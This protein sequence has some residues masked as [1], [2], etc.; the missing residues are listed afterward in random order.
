MRT[1]LLAAVA[2]LALV[3]AN[4]ASAQGLRPGEPASLAEE[5]DVNVVFVGYDEDTIDTDEFLDELPATYE[6]VVRSRLWYGVTEKLGIT[7]TFHYDVSFTDGEWED[8]FFGY[9][10]SIARP[11][12]DVDGLERTLFQDQY[13]AQPGRALDV[14]TNHFI[15]AAA[16]EKYL[17]ANSPGVDTSEYTIFY[18]NWY[19]RSDFEFHTYVKL[20]EP[21]PD[22]GYNFGLNRQTRKIIA[23][24]GTT[25][26]DEE[27]GLGVLGVNRVW[28]HDL[29]AGPES[30]TDNW[31][32]TDADLDGDGQEDYRLPPVWEYGN[33]AAG[34]PRAADALSSDLGKLTRFVA[35]NLLFTTSPLYPPYQNADLIPDTVNL[36]ANTIEGWNKVDAS[37]RYRT[38][39]LLLEEVSDLPTGATY[40]LDQGDIPF[41]GDV[42]NCYLQWIVNVLCYNDRTNYPAF[43]NLFLN[44]ALNG[45]RSFDGN[46][47]YEAALVSYATD[48]APKS[49]GFLGF[50]DDNWIDGTPSGVFS[51]V[52]PFI[53]NVAGYGLTTT[54]IHEYGH[55]SSL[56][57]PHDGYDS[58]LE[59]DYGPGGDTYFA[60]AGDES[61]SM[62]S[63]IDLNWDFSQFDRDNSARH[64][65]AGYYMV[66]NRVAADIL[67]SPNAG[68]A[69]ADLAAADGALT[70]AQM[71]MGAGDYPGTLAHAKAGYKH[72]LT[73]AAKAGVAVEVQQPS[74]FTLLDPTKR[75]NGA[76]KK[77]YSY[78]VDV[79]ANAKRL[80][81]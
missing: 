31:N 29:S 65:A 48:Q 64:H 52:D 67:A 46:A 38:P 7:Q 18:V 37:E 11:E 22:T 32:I 13:N 34:N 74:A 71:A 16:V 12:S 60:W 68:A 8:D 72:V 45:T 14:G 47:D 15:D 36:D 20:N 62:M 17:I 28:F 59:L 50:A 26:D 21:D 70:M 40:S 56:S 1:L 54:E 25:P 9:L 78:D 76:T 4:V 77:G 66:A 61:N 73:G 35:I 41:K 79:K 30:W 39:E 3:V 27:D 10:T 2:A 23:W 6:P 43:A 5:V 75:G 57:H 24:G 81:P 80:G 63:Y 53:A 42:K 69:A 33:A 44:A 49:A 58:E 51:F 19:G 55:H